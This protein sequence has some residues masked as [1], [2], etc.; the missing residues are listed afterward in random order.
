MLKQAGTESFT[1][2]KL[3]INTNNGIVI[4]NKED[5]ICCIAEGSYTSIYLQ[6]K[7]SYLLPKSLV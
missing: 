3:V 7:V 1:N 5:I 2:K 4:L 6:N